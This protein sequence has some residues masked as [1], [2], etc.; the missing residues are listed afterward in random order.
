MLFLPF[1]IA[2]LPVCWAQLNIQSLINN[3]IAN[4]QSEILL[5]SGTHRIYAPIM[6][7]NANKLTLKGSQTGPT[8]L[9][10]NYTS[11]YT[12]YDLLVTYSNTITI[13]NIEF[14]HDPLP[15][16]QGRVAY[17][18]PNKKWFEVDIHAGYSRDQ[19]RFGLNSYI[20]V[21]DANTKRFKQE[22]DITYASR[23]ESTPNGLRVYLRDTTTEYP[24]VQVNE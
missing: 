1:L 15:F 2:F 19:S 9:V 23:T 6:I 18:E 22:G 21:H 7:A 20:H 4:K 12:N 8:K 13:E 17:I 24:N 11:P 3:A 10:F 14:D 5:P 16:T